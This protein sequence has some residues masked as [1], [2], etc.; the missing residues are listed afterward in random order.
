MD[1]SN[2]LNGV[3]PQEDQ[4]GDKKALP[5]GRYNVAI[6]KVEAKTNANTGNK[7]IS[8]QMRVFGKKFNNYVVFDYMG[9]TGSDKQLSYSMPKLKKLGLLSGS[10][11]TDKWVGKKVTVS[12][13]VDKQDN[14]RNMV[15]GYSELDQEC[16]TPTSPISNGAAFTNSD[17]PF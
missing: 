11:D 6:E 5:A 1:L 7:G 16:N 4:G 10:E 9:I 17:L 14:T 13:G 8:L 2:L 12:L 15:W 3:T